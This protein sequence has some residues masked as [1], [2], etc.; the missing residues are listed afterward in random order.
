[1]INEKWRFFKSVIDGE[2]LRINGLNIWDYSWID[3][4]RP[5]ILKD[6]IYGQDHVMRIYLIRNGSEEI[7]FGAGE[8]SNMVWGIYL[9]D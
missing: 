7:I 2:M 3:L 8:F 6:P 4:G 9:P 5:I 1:M